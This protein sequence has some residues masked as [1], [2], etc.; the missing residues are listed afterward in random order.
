MENKQNSIKKE[1]GAP[2]QQRRP[3]NSQQQG[4]EHV[5]QQP[6][7]SASS[8][9]TLPTLEVDPWSTLLHAQ[10]VEVVDLQHIHLSISDQEVEQMLQ[11][12]QE[13]PEQEQSPQRRNQ[14]AG[15]AC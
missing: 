4:I 1:Q 9:A 10:G 7:A 14:R 6:I 11:I 5:G 8:D 15:E 2:S 12:M 3:G 13:Q